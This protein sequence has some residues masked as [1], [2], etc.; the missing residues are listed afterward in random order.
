MTTN[1]KNIHFSSLG[2]LNLSTREPLYDDKSL[3]QGWY[4]K[5]T[6][7]MSGKSAGTFDVYLFSPEHK[8]F[9][10]KVELPWVLGA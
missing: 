8:K 1:F 3:P 9:R 2:N 4:R 5:I 7:R 6:K 10:S